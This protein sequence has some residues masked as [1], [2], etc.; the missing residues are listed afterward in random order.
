[1]LEYPS[2]ILGMHPP[3]VLDRIRYR[4][5]PFRC[6]SG[7][8]WIPSGFWPELNLADD[9]NTEYRNIPIFR[10]PVRTYPEYFRLKD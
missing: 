1:M 4:D 10:I 9:R 7:S 8:S 3:P 5:M 2:K 6:P